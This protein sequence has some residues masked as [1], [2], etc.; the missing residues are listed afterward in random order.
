MQNIITTVVIVLI[1][2]INVII[3]SIPHPT[4]YSFKAINYNPPPIG[5]SNITVWC[6]NVHQLHRVDTLNG[7]IWSSYYYLSDDTNDHFVYNKETNI[8]DKTTDGIIQFVSDYL[9]NM[10]K[11]EIGTFNVQSCPNVIKK[12]RLCDYWNFPGNWTFVFT[13]K[14]EEEQSE[15]VIVLNDLGKK[16]L[17]FYSY[18]TG[19]D[20][21]PKDVFQLPKQCKLSQY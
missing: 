8:C 18:S 10:A 6:D 5:V 17:V 2:M 11:K 15:P 3:H 4:Q 19:P 16:D 14:E 1:M 21:V 12:N 9:G 20:A 13:H 7:T